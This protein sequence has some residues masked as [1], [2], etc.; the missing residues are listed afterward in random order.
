MPDPFKVPEPKTVNDPVTWIVGVSVNAV[1]P[2]KID[3][4][5]T[6]IPSNASRVPGGP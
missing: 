1:E 2:E 6:I 3:D 5:V 4:P